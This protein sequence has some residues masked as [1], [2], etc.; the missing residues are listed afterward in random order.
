MLVRWGKLQL[1]RGFSPAVACFAWA[2]LC[3]QTSQPAP[4]PR[5]HADAFW[6]VKPPDR[7]SPEEVRDLLEHSP[8]G[9]VSTATM[10]RPL[11]IHLAS[12]EPAIEAENRERLA[13]RYRTDPGPSFEE[14]QI[15]LREGHVIV[16]AVLIPDP[17]AMSDAV[18]SQSLER[19][20][21]LHIGKRQY[22]TITSFPPG[23]GDPYL[24]YVFPRDVKP[25]DKSLFFDIYIPGVTYPQ[26]H[27]EFVLKDLI[28]RGKPAY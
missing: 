9:T 11:P 17:Q 16:L 13:R 3:A 2:A 6:N 20:S 26:R 15:M 24:R 22:K 10:G 1:A 21:L 27:I 5:P 4:P 25:G 28:Y 23:S 18:E 19:D 7:W 14:Y 8:W 12:A